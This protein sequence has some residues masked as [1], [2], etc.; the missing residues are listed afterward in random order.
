M[1]QFSV[2]IKQ[3]I[4]VRD[5]ES[6][7]LVSSPARQYLSLLKLDNSATDCAPATSLPPFNGIL[8]HS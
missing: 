1:E 3:A 2:Y 8:V 5:G 6:S 7:E 4:A